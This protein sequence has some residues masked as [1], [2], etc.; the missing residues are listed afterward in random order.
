VGLTEDELADVYKRR[1]AGFRRG[2]AAIVGDND[3]AH[4]LV[5]DA[6][7]NALSSRGRF[8]GGTPEAWVWRSVER[9][10]LDKR[11]ELGRT[12]ELG[13]DLDLTV[14]ESENDPELAR[15]VGELPARRRLV[16]FLR[17]FADLSY[18]EI[19]RLCGIE[20]GTVAATLAQAHAELK[21]AL[22]GTEVR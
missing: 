1:Y 15:A 19:A 7:A 18:A 16:V 17:Y 2:A 22:E 12:T 9:R 5:Q 4:D 8:R 11:R 6:F 21:L 13:D 10:A 14:V 20:E 3:L